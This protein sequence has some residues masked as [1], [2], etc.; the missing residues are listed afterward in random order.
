M[1]AECR[2]RRQTLTT[3][4]SIRAYAGGYSHGPRVGG[5]DGVERV[6]TG[7]ERMQRRSWR[8]TERGRTTHVPVGD[9]RRTS[10]AAA[11]GG[12]ILIPVE[13]CPPRQA[14]TLS[15]TTKLKTLFRVFRS[16]SG[17]TA[18]PSLEGRPQ[19]AGSC[20]VSVAR[21]FRPGLVPA[22]PTADVWRT[23]AT[24]DSFWTRMRP[25]ARMDHCH[26]PKQI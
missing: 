21:G 13:K 26:S 9:A 18:E 19:S 16:T 6:V 5:G 3:D 23:S 11:G 14:G 15:T 12:W 24:R 17:F 22:V 4:R 25:M 7:Q 1:V 10:K 8:R 20:S 2:T